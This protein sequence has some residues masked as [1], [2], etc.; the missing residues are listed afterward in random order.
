MKLHKMA[1]AHSAEHA[2]AHLQAQT[3]E[4]QQ[5]YL[6][7][8]ATKGYGYPPSRNVAPEGDF[9]IQVV[10]EE[11]KGTHGV[12]LSN[13]VNAQYFSEITLG[14]PP[15]SFKVV[16]DTGS[17]NLWVPSTKCSSIACFLHAKVRL[18][19]LWVCAI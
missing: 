17:S 5:K 4:L 13:Y 16:L 10:S 15:Q 11:H 9:Q 7:S 18:V 8:G 19:C 14:T 6:G 1:P 12:P 3:L 2:A